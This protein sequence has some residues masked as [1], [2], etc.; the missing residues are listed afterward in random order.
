MGALINFVHGPSFMSQTVYSIFYMFDH[1]SIAIV[2]AIGAT[3]TG[4]CSVD[5]P[6]LGPSRLQNILHPNTSQGNT[7]KGISII[8]S[9]SNFFANYCSMV[10]A[11]FKDPNLHVVSI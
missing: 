10:V 9:R 8:H 4:L 1:T 7:G 6:S 5:H 3:T 11:D 2:A